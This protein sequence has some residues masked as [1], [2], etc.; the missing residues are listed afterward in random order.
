MVAA[1][2]VMGLL[3]T[4]SM[5]PELKGASLEDRPRPVRGEGVQENDDRKSAPV[6]RAPVMTLAAPTATATAKLPS[7]F[8]RR[9]TTATIITTENG[10][11]SQNRCDL[12]AEL[13]IGTR[14]AASMVSTSMGWRR[15]H[16]ST[17][18]T[19]QP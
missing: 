5:V 15:S 16:A 19:G 14:R 4:I 11:D 3:A 18:V 1:V 13:P 2:P 9:N 17:D 6:G 7:G 8:L 12:I 10:T